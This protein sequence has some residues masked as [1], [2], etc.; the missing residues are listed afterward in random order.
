L[1]RH[2]PC[3][4]PALFCAPLSLATR[5]ADLPKTSIDDLYR[6]CSLYGNI[7]RIKVLFAKH[8]NALVMFSD[9]VYAYVFAVRTAVGLIAR[10]QTIG[11]S[12][13]QRMP[14]SEDARARSVVTTHF[15]HAAARQRQTDNN[16]SG[17]DTIVAARCTRRRR[18][19][20][21]RAGSRDIVG[22]DDCHNERCW[23]RCE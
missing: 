4:L 18:E 2:F 20:Q 19:W 11:D 22:V 1:I 9:V 12:A 8:D 17:N 23:W 15:D 16:A 13:P 14:V 21:R 3:L 6:L 10:A 7:T 5:L